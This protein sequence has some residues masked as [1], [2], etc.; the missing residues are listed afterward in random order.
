MQQV[1]NRRLLRRR[2]WQFFG[3]ELLPLQKLSVRRGSFY[4]I[5]FHIRQLLLWTSHNERALQTNSEYIFSALVL[6]RCNKSK[7]RMYARPR[8]EKPPP[9]SDARPAAAQR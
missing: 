8:R 9:Q 4:P 5:W 3:L 6:A 1:F 2:Q 7:C